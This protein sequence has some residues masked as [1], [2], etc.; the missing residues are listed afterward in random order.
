MVPDGYHSSPVLSYPSERHSRIF[1][2]YPN[3]FPSAFIDG[4]SLSL[5]S[6]PL[7]KKKGISFSGGRASKAGFLTRWGER[8]AAK[9]VQQCMGLWY[10][11]KDDDEMTIKREKGGGARH[12]LN[13]DQTMIPNLSQ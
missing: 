11:R 4:L 13:S 10:G 12:R 9:G 2:I 8:T 6:S 5:S 1:R 7:S 3:S